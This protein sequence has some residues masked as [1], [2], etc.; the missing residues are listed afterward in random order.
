MEALFREASEELG[1]YDFQPYSLGSYVFESKVE[2]EL[3]HIFAAVGDYEIHPD[4][5][6]VIDGRFWSPGQIRTATGKGKLTP[7][8]ESE[9]RRIRKQLEALL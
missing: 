4:N 8:F 7:N 3:V 2:R 6:E 5:D 1:L 9:Y